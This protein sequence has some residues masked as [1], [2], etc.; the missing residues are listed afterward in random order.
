MLRKDAYYK[1]FGNLFVLFVISYISFMYYIFMMVNF[2][3]NLQ[4]KP[5]QF[6]VYLSRYIPSAPS[7]LEK[8]YIFFFHV[9][10][11]LLIASFTRTLVTDPGKVP[12]YWV[13]EKL[14]ADVS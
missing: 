2:L 7:T 8:V 4:G 6:S 13:S 9:F 11:L 10:F 14:S 5:P 12:L 3:E 1:I